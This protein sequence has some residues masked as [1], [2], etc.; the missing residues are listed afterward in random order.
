MNRD[1]KYILTV[2]LTAASALI[3]LAASATAQNAVTTIK[4]DDLKWE[5]SP[6]LPKGAQRVTLIG[7]PTKAGEVVVSR[8][9]LPPNYVVPPH[10]HP[11]P[12]TLTL[13]SGSIGFGVG[14]TVDTTGELHKPGAFFA[15]PANS[16]HY[17][18]TG[19][20]GAIFEVHT[21]GPGGIEYINPTD[22][23]RKDQGQNR[24]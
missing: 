6:S 23:P 15:Q 3:A 14:E 10:R 7:D 20:E 1:R 22:D 8:S 13:L 11:S 21:F 4:S 18:W 9:K 16:P 17:L 24:G 5:D 12:E 19:D 2:S